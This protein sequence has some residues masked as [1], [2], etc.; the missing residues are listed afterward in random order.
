MMSSGKSAIMPCFYVRDETGLLPG[1]DND[2]DLSL[3]IC[4]C[5]IFFVRCLY[6]GEMF[7]VP[8]RLGVI[9]LK[10]EISV[11]RETLDPA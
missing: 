2:R 11:V 1:R 8:S 9:L 4:F 3:H 7:L 10:R 5:M 6:E